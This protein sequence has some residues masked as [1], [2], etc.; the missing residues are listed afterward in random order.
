MKTS[1]PI[2]N[3]GLS[4]AMPDLDRIDQVVDA[5]AKANDVPTSTFPSQ[6]PQ[7][8]PAGETGVVALHQKKEPK[9]TKNGSTP[10]PLKKLSV[11][12]PDYV[13]EAIGLRSAKG[14]TRKFIVLESLR[15]NDF[16]IHDIDMKE[17]GRRGRE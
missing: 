1:T 6:V 4:Q 2:K 13:C 9:A 15:A 17:D 8:K 11:M 10:A 16:T 5:F 7:V 12:V 3:L 14:I